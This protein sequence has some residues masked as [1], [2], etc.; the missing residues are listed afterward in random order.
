M[1][2]LVFEDELIKLE[3]AVNEFSDVVIGFED[4]LIE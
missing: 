3:D 4:K 2:E 1:C